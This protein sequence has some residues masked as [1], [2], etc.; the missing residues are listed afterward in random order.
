MNLFITTDY[1]H[2]LEDALIESG[3]A[4]IV[5]YEQQRLLS[6]MPNEKTA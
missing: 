5:I 3:Y 6:P 4:T 1:D 2:L